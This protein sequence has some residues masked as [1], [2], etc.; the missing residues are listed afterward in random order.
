MRNGQNFFEPMFSPM[1]EAETAYDENLTMEEG[2]L[3]FFCSENGQ[4]KIV[5]SLK[6]G[7]KKID[8]TAE[9]S[10]KSPETAKTIKHRKLRKT[11]KNSNK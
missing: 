10:L 8:K 7:D 1:T 5:K 11:V 6:V 4:Q 9:N 2:L 3:A